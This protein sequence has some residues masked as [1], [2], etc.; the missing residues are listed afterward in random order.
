[1]ARKASAVVAEATGFGQL[2]C[3]STE[4]EGVPSDLFRVNKMAVSFAIATQL[5]DAH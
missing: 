2:T 1:M 5:K 4:V 3:D